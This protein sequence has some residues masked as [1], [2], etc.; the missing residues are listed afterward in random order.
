MEIVKETFAYLCIFCILNGH[1]L[2]KMK[3][4]NGPKIVKYAYFFGKFS[5]KTD[6]SLKV[7]INVTESKILVAKKKINIFTT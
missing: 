3:N 7:K 2:L 5:R 6:T 1:F 4:A